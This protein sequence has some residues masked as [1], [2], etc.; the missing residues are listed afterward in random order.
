MTHASREARIQRMSD[1]VV[2]SYIHDISARTAPG[3]PASTKTTGLA[4]VFSAA[5]SERRSARSR[6]R[7]RDASAK[8]ERRARGHELRPTQ[9]LTRMG[10]G[11]R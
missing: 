8:T 3:T 11:A 7:R 5:R 9:A 10:G 1:G 4:V 2:A 6:P